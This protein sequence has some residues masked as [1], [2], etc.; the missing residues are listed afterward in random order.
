MKARIE[1]C[2][3]LVLEQIEYLMPR[4]PLIVEKLGGPITALVPACLSPH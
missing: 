4:A 1:L 2:F 3:E